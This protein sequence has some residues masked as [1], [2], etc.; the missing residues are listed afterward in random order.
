[1]LLSLLLDLLTLVGILILVCITIFLIAFAVFGL[2]LWLYASTVA[3]D[4]NKKT[5]EDKKEE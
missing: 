4:D 1:M 2:R 5:T 3:I